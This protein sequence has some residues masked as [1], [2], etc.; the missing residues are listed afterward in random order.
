MAIRGGK[1]VN[2]ATVFVVEEDNEFV[3]TTLGGEGDAA[4]ADA[5]KCLALL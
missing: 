5:A 4:A 1:T 2:L 3:E